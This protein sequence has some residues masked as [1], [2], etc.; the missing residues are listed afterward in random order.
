MKLNSLG[1]FIKKG[2]I[3]TCW[4]YNVQ[5]VNIFHIQ[6]KVWNNQAL[7]VAWRPKNYPEEGQNLR[8]N[9]KNRMKRKIISNISENQ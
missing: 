2:Y 1:S 6:Q 8:E 4:N 9:V 3:L 7:H 5:S